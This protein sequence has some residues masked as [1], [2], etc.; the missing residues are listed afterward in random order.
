MRHAILFILTCFIFSVPVSA[1]RSQALC[2]LDTD[3]RIDGQNCVEMGFRIWAGLSTQGLEE[4]AIIGIG[5]AEVTLRLDEL[6]D[7]GTTR[8]ELAEAP[9]EGKF[10]FID[11]VILVKDSSVVPTAGQGAAMGITVASLAGSI[12]S[13]IPSVYAVGSGFGVG[14]FDVDGLE[15]RRHTAGGSGAREVT[16]ENTPIILGVSG[17][18]STWDSMIAALDNTVVLRVIIRYRTIDTTDEFR[19]PANPANLYKPMKYTLLFLLCTVLFAS[20]AIAQDSCKGSETGFVNGIPCFS[21]GGLMFSDVEGQG[22]EA[23]A[24]VGEIDGSQIVEGSIPSSK[25]AESIG[26]AGASI[27]F[28]GLAERRANV[29]YLGHVLADTPASGYNSCPES[30]QCIRSLLR[31]SSLN[32][33]KRRELL[34]RYWMLKFYRRVVWE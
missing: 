10:L 16:A 31:R 32:T 18:A 30:S 33:S 22:V 29:L 6:T 9:G 13:G 14:V 15:V 11:W 23:S 34:S 5:S 19:T 24:L 21:F 26:A 17:F 8:I 1:Q 4:D 2:Q 28:A 20:T 25:M 27:I 12:I 7:L 3:G